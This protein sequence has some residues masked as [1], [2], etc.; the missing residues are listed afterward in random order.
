[1]ESNRSGKSGRY[2]RVLNWASEYGLSLETCGRLCDLVT[3][4]SASRNATGLEVIEEPRSAWMV[5]WSRPM[6][7][8]AQ[9]S[10][11][12]SSAR[13]ADLAGG[14]HPADHVAAEDVED[15]VQVEVGPLRRAAQLGDVP[16]PHLV[17]RGRD[18]L[19][20]SRWQGGWPAGGVPDSPRPD[21][22]AGTSSRSS[23]GRPPRRAAWPTPSIAR[24]RPAGSG[25][26]GECGGPRSGRE[27]PTAQPSRHRRHGAW[28][29]DAVA[30]WPA[31]GGSER[32]RR[33][34]RR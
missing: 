21:A 26:D 19:R 13:A 5:S 12:S 32:S 29:R 27:A 22:A 11:I 34:R 23:P 31:A 4:R 3:P 24:V 30:R 20:A 6:P 2:F 1:M 15:H 33:R 28:W 9:V 14:D 16:R 10:A 8:L 25:A 17:R 18:Q 7:C